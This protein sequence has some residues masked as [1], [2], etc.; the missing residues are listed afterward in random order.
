MPPPCCAPPPASSESSPPPAS[1][2]V[3]TKAA[4]IPPA[5]FE[6]EGWQSLFDGE[7]LG[8]WRET[9]YAGRGEVRGESGCLVLGM[10]SPFTGIRWTNDFPTVNYEIAFDAMRTLGS[11]FFCGLTVP[12]GTS[13]CTFIVGGWGGGLVGLSSLDGYDAS[14]NETTKFMNFDTGR[15]YRIRV[16]LT[17]ERFEAWIDRDK[18]VDVERADRHFA[19]RPGDIELSAPLGIS[20]WQTGAAVR[21][22]RWR[23]VT[24]PGSPAK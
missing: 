2:E 23:R 20:A 4:T 7:N 21:E 19:L 10:G 1:S 3:L 8:D 18:L 6:G 16:R 22:I 13:H 14:E 5:P 15:W 17:A 24:T 9:D 12:V 11:D